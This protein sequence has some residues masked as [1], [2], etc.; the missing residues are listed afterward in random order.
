[1]PVR[2]TALPPILLFTHPNVGVHG[3]R[4]VVAM[5]Q[6]VI[7]N[8]ERPRVNLLV[9]ALGL[10]VHLKVQ[11]ARDSRTCRQAHQ[12]ERQQQ[13]W[14]PPASARHRVLWCCLFSVVP[15]LS[16][17]RARLFVGLV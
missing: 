7:S 5:D 13:R 16:L 8:Y 15:S 11:S 10:R 3:L 14:L 17:S 9:H 12:R 6:R 2:V 1:M 4:G